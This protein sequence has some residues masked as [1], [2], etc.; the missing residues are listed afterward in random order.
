MMETLLVPIVE[1]LIRLG[2]EKWKDVRKQRHAPFDFLLQDSAGKT[3]ALE[4]LAGGPSSQR[5]STILRRL[6]G[7]RKPPDQLLL[8]T[9]ETPTDQARA[10]LE[11]LVLPSRT[12]VD[13]VDINSLAEKLDVEV[14]GDLATA[15]GIAELQ[16]RAMFEDLE[17]YDI[18]SHVPQVVPT[19]HPLADLGV[20]QTL[21]AQLPFSIIKRLPSE[22][23]KVASR[24]SFGSRVPEV[25]VVLSDIKNFSQL[26]EC[27]SPEALT[28]SM[29]IYYSEARDLVWKF[30]GTLENFIGDAILAIFGYPFPDG[31]AAKRAVDFS[32]KLVL[33]GCRVFS[34][35]LEDLDVEIE[36]GTRIGIATGDIWPLNIG[37][38]GIQLSLVGSVKNTA[39]DLEE[40]CVVNGILLTQRT[41]HRLQEVAPKYAQSLPFHQVLLER[42]QET[43][44]GPRMRCWQIPPLCTCG[45]AKQ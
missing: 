8:V 38:R 30:K 33:L 21:I 39:A 44:A 11:Q 28:E 22:R 27:S 42:S 16:R 7:T 2:I 41:R 25:T 13:I 26:V 9:P 4:L 43:T 1:S 20:L 14:P 36:T 24:L 15:R 37:T 10:L 12:E 17:Q 18:E 19:P 45:V 6:E 31:H 40:Q 32:R 23:S 5:L 3:I 34:K 29:S 35:W